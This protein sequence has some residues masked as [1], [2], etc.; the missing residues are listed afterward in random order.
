MSMNFKKLN[1][2]KAVMQ[3]ISKYFPKSWTLYTH[4]K[5]EFDLFNYGKKSGVK[6]QQLFI[7]H[8]LQKNLI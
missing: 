1:K 8:N 5:V 4:I 3:K 2:N 7:N 6:K